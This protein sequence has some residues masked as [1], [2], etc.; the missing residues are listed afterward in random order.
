MVLQVWPQ[1]Q[2]WKLVRNA[3]HHPP[4]H[5]L[6]REFQHR[7]QRSVLPS[8]VADS[9]ARSGLRT[10]GSELKT[11]HVGRIVQVGV[12]GWNRTT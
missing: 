12:A 9:D 5:R 3:S 2:I 11:T 6:N 4:P 10:T 8:P 7:P 1:N